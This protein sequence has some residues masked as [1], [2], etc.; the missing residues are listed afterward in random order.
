[1]N[2]IRI[3]YN[4]IFSAQ[5]IVKIKYQKN[6]SVREK[7]KKKTIPFKIYIRVYLYIHINIYY[8]YNSQNIQY[9]TQFH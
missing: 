7:Y 2:K 3:L 8:I 9:T 6:G 1:M 5:K 4:I